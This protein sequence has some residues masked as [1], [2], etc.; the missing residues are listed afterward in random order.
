MLGRLVAHQQ[1]ASWDSC[2]RSRVPSEAIT[3]TL[4]MPSGEAAGQND[5]TDLGRKQLAAFGVGMQVRV[6]VDRASHGCRSSAKR[7]TASDCGVEH[8]SQRQV[9]Q[10]PLRLGGDSLRLGRH[11]R[12][13]LGLR[14]G[15]WLSALRTARCGHTRLTRDSVQRAQQRWRRSARA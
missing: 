9:A 5:G 1:L 10:T 7:V 2:S 14:L 3:S 13:G 12:L 15:S 8:P 6:N 4:Q 11:F